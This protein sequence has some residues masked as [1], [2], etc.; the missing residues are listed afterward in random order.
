[1]YR[2]VYY[3]ETYSQQLRKKFSLEKSNSEKCCLELGRS[4]WFK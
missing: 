3:S 1:M 2:N 4:V